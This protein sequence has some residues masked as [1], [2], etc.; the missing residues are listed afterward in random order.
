MISNETKKKFLPWIEKYRPTKLD[1]IVSQH[2]TIL[3]L[4]KFILSESLPHL[5]FF[6]PPGTGKTST[7][8]CCIREI[9]GEYSI[10]MVLELNASN[11]RG[12]DTVRTK[13]KNFINNRNSVF[14]PQERRNIFKL[15]ILD[16]IDSMTFDAQGMLRYTIEKNSESTRFCLI[17]NDI[18]KINIAL[19]SRC[20]IYYFHPICPKNVIELLYNI[21]DTENIKLEKKSI[22]TI[23]KISK[24]DLR[25]AINILQRLSQTIKNKI[26][27]DDVYLITG[28][29]MPQIITK[30]LKIFLKLQNDPKQL[31]NCIS[32]INFLIL[33]YNITIPCLLEELK[34]EILQSE[35]SIPQKIF[36]I[37]KFAQSEL[38]DISNIDWTIIV[39]II[40]SIFILSNDIK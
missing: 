5:L 31:S 16:E 37:D 33:E 6:G 2:E 30:I 15:V 27:V 8:R 18:D 13:I 20:T 4:K 26:L 21:A 23:A 36:I 32:K 29:C 7:I 11:E 22:N 40:A 28:Y 10:C 1:N 35:L 9:Y 39:T 34:N 3:S 19:Q 14:L 25:A 38:Y 12:I 17:C 24:G